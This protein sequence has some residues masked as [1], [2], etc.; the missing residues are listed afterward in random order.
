MQ[1][2]AQAG[3][4]EDIQAFLEKSK[5]YKGMKLQGVFSH[6]S[7]ADEADLTYTKKQVSMFEK[8]IDQIEVF[9]NDPI[10]RHV[11]NS[12]GALLYKGSW[13]DMVRAGLSLYGVNPRN[14][15]VPVDL[16]PVM[17]FKTR[18]GFIKS[19]S[20][21]TVLGYNRTFKTKKSSII[22]TLPVGYADGLN[23]RLSNKMEF[24]VKGKRVKQIGTI[25]M[26]MCLI[27]VTKLPNV[28]M[29]E[30]VVILGSQG[31]DNIPIEELA[32]KAETIPY[33]IF[34]GISKR[35]PRI[36]V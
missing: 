2:F 36:Y 32:A 3:G 10:V 1:L 29:G 6:L 33:E 5:S 11:A 24:L 16:Q 34:C 14:S 7:S 9:N 25:C 28:D 30:E 21:N 35:V 4:S 23:R 13:F 17:S 27:D 26:D 15:K 31:K 12:A 8:V 18:V 22:A 19:V 20:A